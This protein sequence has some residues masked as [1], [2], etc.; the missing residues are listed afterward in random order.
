MIKH[1][2]YDD[3]SVNTSQVTFSAGNPSSS[4]RQ[5]RAPSRARLARQESSRSFLESNGVVFP[6]SDDDVL[7]KGCGDLKK[8]LRRSVKTLTLEEREEMRMQLAAEA[9]GDAEGVEW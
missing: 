1:S 4:G 3:V 6:S 9:G 8:S 7:I 5:R 2:R